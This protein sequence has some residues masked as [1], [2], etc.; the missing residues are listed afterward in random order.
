MQNLGHNN[1]DKCIKNFCVFFS[2]RNKCILMTTFLNFK[3]PIG[4]LTL[5]IVHGREQMTGQ[6][7]KYETFRNYFTQFQHTMVCGGDDDDDE[8][9]W[10]S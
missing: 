2:M 4:P 8:T 10:H 1:P 9:H 5:Y 7:L 6:R 3:N